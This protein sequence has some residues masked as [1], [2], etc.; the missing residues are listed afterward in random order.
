MLNM[1]FYAD[2]DTI[3][4]RKQQRINKNNEAENAKRIPHTYH[5]GDDILIRN[6]PSRKFGSTAYSGPYLISSARNNGT[7]RYRKGKL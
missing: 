5:V 3:R 7:L 2:W 1:E 4:K 6:E